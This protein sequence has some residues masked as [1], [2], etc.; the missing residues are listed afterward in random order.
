MSNSFGNGGKKGSSLR[1][2]LGEKSVYKRVCVCVCVKDIYYV[3]KLLVCIC[4]EDRIAGNKTSREDNAKLW[5]FSE[6]QTSFNL[7]RVTVMKV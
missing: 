3:C 2:N 1:E 6:Y 4:M 5:D 7:N